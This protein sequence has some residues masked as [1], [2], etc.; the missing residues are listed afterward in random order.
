MTTRR[1]AC[2]CGTLEVACEGDPV[3]ISMCH[4]PS[5]IQTEILPMQPFVWGIPLTDIDRPFSQLISLVR[6]GSCP[7]SE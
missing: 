4:W 1:A 6:P 5:N 3:R 2:S 7:A